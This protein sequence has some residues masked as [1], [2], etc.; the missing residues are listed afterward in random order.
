MGRGPHAER[1]G[2]RGVRH[3]HDQPVQQLL[4]ERAGRQPGRPVPGPDRA[5]ARRQRADR[6][7]DQLADHRGQRADHRP[8]ARRLH[9]GSGEPAGRHPQVRLAAAQLHAADCP[10]GLRAARPQLAGGGA[11]RRDPRAGA[12]GD[13]H[14]HLLPRPRPGLGVQP[15]D[16]RAARLPVSGAAEPLPALHPGAVRH[17]RPRGRD[18]HHRGLV[19]RVLRTAPRRGAGRQDA[20]PGRGER[21]ETRQAHDPGVRHGVVPRRGPAVPLRDQ[22]RAGLRLHARPD[23]ADRRAR[24]VPV[25]QAHGHPAR[26]DEVLRRRAP[27]VRARPGAARRQGAVALRGPAN[28]AH[29]APG[30][31]V[32]NLGWLFGH[33]AGAGHLAGPATS[34]QE[35]D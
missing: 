13:L 11:G 5:S 18:R 2:R 21:L 4:R 19:H 7:G 17:R 9:P 6:P 15:A 16:R 14:V 26:Q 1:Q 24:G 31:R 25:H 27:L 12:R 28:G 3:A 35:E 30:H 22:R 32:E 23:H 33:L 8:G 20:A 10:L 29:P 34:Q